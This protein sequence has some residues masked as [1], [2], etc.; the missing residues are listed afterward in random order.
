MRAFLIIGA[1]VAIFWTG[2]FFWFAYRNSNLGTGP[3]V[4][5]RNEQ[6]LLAVSRNQNLI[7]GIQEEGANLA[8]I[9]DSRRWSALALRQKK[10]VGM[11][12]W[13]IQANRGPIGVV[14]VK[15]GL[16][17]VARVDKGV[18]TGL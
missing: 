5:C 18:W 4:A 13:C 2:V 1:A 17:E 14:L 11:A 15:S 9:V 3:D 8:V 7:I 6:I 12:A 10:E 16:D